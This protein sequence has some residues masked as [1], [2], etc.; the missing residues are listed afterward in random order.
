M[1]NSQVIYQA[2]R[3]DGICAHGY[4]KAEKLMKTFAFV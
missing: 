4:L 3:V 1:L 2:A